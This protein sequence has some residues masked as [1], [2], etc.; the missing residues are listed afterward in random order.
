MF[1]VYYIHDHFNIPYLV[2]IT[3][4]N[5]GDGLSQGIICNAQHSTIADLWV[6]KDGVLDLQCRYFVAPALYDVCAG[7]PKDLPALVFPLSCCGI[8]SPAQDIVL[9]LQDNV[10]NVIFLEGLHHT[11]VSSFIC[12]LFWALIIEKGIWGYTCSIAFAVI[13]GTGNVTFTLS[14]PNGL[15]SSHLPWHWLIVSKLRALKLLQ[16]CLTL[17]L[18]YWFLQRA[19]LSIKKL[20]GSSRCCQSSL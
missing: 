2:S 1:T 17:G 5:G 11:Q 9:A 3:R 15:L 19:K 18:G 10:P 13:T 6:R 12:K 4:N 20:T 7:S 16:Y 8:A 14:R